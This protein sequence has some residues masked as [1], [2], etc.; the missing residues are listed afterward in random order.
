M[1]PGSDARATHQIT[2]YLTVDRQASMAEF[3]HS[4]AS[5]PLLMKG[6]SL[7]DEHSTIVYAIEDNRFNM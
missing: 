1:L 4:T 2:K 7:D 5:L 3:Y 6:L